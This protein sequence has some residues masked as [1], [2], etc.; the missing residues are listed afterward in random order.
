[1]LGKY[2]LKHKLKVTS[3][4]LYAPKIYVDLPANT[5]FNLLEINGNNEDVEYTLQSTPK[6]WFIVKM[7]KA[8]FKHYF[9]KI[10][11]IRAH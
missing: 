8:Q 1:M 11:L 9:Q 10:R 3:F 6:K 5:H 2:R 7:N 4:N